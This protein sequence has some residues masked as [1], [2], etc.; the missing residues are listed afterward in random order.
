MA[1]GVQAVLGLGR[2]GSNRRRVASASLRQAAPR[3]VALA[4]VIVLA[5]LSSD[6]ADWQP[7]SLVVALGV[8]MIVADILAVTV[9]RIRVSAGLMV[10]VVAMALLGP[11]PAAAIGIVAAVP[12]AAVNRVRP[13][14][15]LINMALFGFL[16]LVGGLMFDVVGAAVGLGPA[17]SAYALLVLPI[18]V[19][20]LAL[21]LGVLAAPSPELDSDARRRLL[22]ES[23]LPTLPY[24]LMNALMAT[25]TVFVWA[26]A[27]LAAVAG[28][29][30]VLVITV[31][32]LR[33][34]G[35]ALTHGDERAAEV[36]RL[37]SDRERLLTE[38][39]DAE[40]RERARLA[41]S[42]HDGPVQRL[43]AIRQDAAEG[44]SPA[45]IADHI[46]VAL[47][48]ARA[49]ISAFHP[50]AVRECG[51]EASL[52]A[53]IAPFPA[54]R[55]VVLTVHS[56]VDDDSPQLALPLRLAQELTVNAVKHARPD[57]IDVL[58][59]DE[60]DRIVLEVDD[61][62]VGIDD[63]ASR[64]AVQAGHV[65]LAMVRRR[66]ED[67]GGTLE[68]ATRADGGTHSRVV[69]PSQFA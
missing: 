55:S 2:A 33:T 64:R 14:S 34:V 13:V 46:D 68:I 57:R 67:L 43:S 60:A 31:P 61:D 4:L 20:L 22:R 44:T 45:Q 5:A 38:V 6:R 41:E 50:V 15:A 1:G 53:A 65:G 12:D 54:A 24:E 39:I 48:E 30:L 42:L 3:L 47:A 18:S 59:T 28:L 29:L 51:F 63:A 17:D 8:T 19:L 16:G 7:V 58:L 23:G 9:R 49:I 35:N 26:Q 69:L 36:A 66:V 10:Q 32:L 56:T 40:E 11:A 27:G 52:R 21:N 37:A 25:A 62:G